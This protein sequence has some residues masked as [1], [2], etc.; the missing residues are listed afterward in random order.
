[1]GTSV[2]GGATILALLPRGLRLGQPLP[3]SSAGHQAGWVP[4]SW[5]RQEKA[6]RA[7]CRRR[8][9]RRGGAPKSRRRQKQ[10]RPRRGCAGP[11]REE[12]HGGSENTER[13]RDGAGGGE[14]EE[15]QLR[16]LEA[17]MATDSLPGKPRPW[18]QHGGTSPPR[19]LSA[20]RAW[21]R[22]GARS[23][24]GSPHSQ[25]KTLAWA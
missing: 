7:R 3:A 17:A 21:W 19:D 8:E 23:C 4:T 14:R 9:G 20:R 12:R 2:H 16:P 25:D 22:C 11:G 6:G 18:A 13:G 10:G 1:M 15:N 5:G 24:R